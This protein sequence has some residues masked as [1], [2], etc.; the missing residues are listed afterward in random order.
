MASTAGIEDA[1]RDPPS[2][3]SP[4]A[5]F[6]DMSDDSEREY[7]TI[8]HS[9]SGKGVKLLYTKSKVY[10]HP[11][12]S[13]RDNVPGYIA[14]MQQKPAAGDV[15]TPSTSPEPS[16]RRAQR[17][18][19]LLA[20][21]PESSLGEASSTY[22]KVESST[23]PSPPQHSPLVPAPPVTT[24]HSSS[25]GTYAFSVPVSEVFSIL[26]RP[27]NSGWW[28]GSVVINTRAGDSFPALFFHDSECQSTIEQRKRL[29]REN[30]S[31]SSPEGSGGVFWGGDELIRWLKSY[32]HVER[33]AQEP[34]IYLIDPNDADKLSFGSGGKPT[35]HNVRN[36]LEGKHKDEPAMHKQG[37][38]PVTK[39][40]K[41]AR[42]SFL[43]KMAQVTTFTRRTA[44]AVAENKN[45]PPQ[46]KRLMQ[47]PQV[48]TVSDEFDSA[49]LY[50]A[51][52]AMGIAEQSEK[53]RNQRIWTAKDVLEMEETGVG[54]FEILDLDA[55][56]IS[57]ADKRKPVSLQEWKGYFNASTGRLERTPDEVKE[58][59]FH[60]GLATDDGARKEAWLFLLGVY[61]WTSTKE[62][63]RAKMNSLRDEYIRLKGA[64]WERMVDEQGT[65]E[66]REWWKEQKMRIEK[67][68]HRTDRHIP[69]FA[70]EDIPHPDP[71][72]PFAEAGTNVHLEQM[73]DML[74]TYN[75]YN[76]DLGYVQ[77]MS[78]LLA[79]IYAIEQDDAVAFWGFVK[80]MERME[81]N[82]LRDQSGMRLQLLTLD[83]LCQ[84][85]DP[86]LYEHLQKLDSTNFF[87]FF[88]MLLV[89]FKREFSF[90]DILRL[91]ET[92][93]TDF[94]SANFH[95]FV[96]MAIL[97]KHRN[98]IMEHLKGFDE[99]LKYVNELSGSIDL[100]STLVR[101]EALFKRFQ[102][103]V[104][105][106]DRKSSFPA[107]P[108]ARQRVPLPLPP[109]PATSPGV[110]G[111]PR[112]ASAESGSGARRRS[113]STAVA[114]TTGRERTVGDHVGA[115][116]G[117][118]KERVVT[119]EL[120]ALLSREV[121]KLDKVEVRAHGGGVGS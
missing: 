87:F 50:L 20:W 113:S 83:Q 101:A 10:V 76:R 69:L 40:L 120:R 71:D 106:I 67:D 118:E 95:L 102:R 77:G 104:E 44:Q 82:F 30:F 56:N 92:L 3:P 94:L 16:A 41:Q 4:T 46:V 12:S 73:K 52:W 51:R 21:V 90:E 78:D 47:S 117:A 66:E 11:T 48:Q 115:G 54:E 42:W 23:S 5:S 32:V 63:R 88:R 26:V 36:V 89:W 19:L 68:V 25:L 107:A 24:T 61:D 43:E 28:H 85:L 114:V 64:W 110:D 121:P 55:Q 70:G 2:P 86:K 72:S 45:L 60:G 53:E 81:R 103:V 9:R 99:V 49:R 8:R 34:S 62:E 116:V 105:A 22:A 7:S 18:S 57:L 33:S 58:R 100:P 27:P 108:V 39:A 97:E 96:A 17:R 79:P 119:P 14:L 1:S 15:T 84:L 98:V 109:P 29:Q 13:A 35:S 31:I 111:R 37:E 93:W 74:L 112:Q 59:I 6:Y 38:D 80:F 75:E 91:Y 65:L